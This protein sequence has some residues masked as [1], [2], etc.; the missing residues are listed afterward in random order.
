MLGA[1]GFLGRAVTLRLLRDD[2]QVIAWARSPE[3]ARS[4]LGAEVEIADAGSGRAGLVAALERCDAVINLAGE[5]IAGRWSRA[6]RRRITASR[7]GVTEQLVSAIAA[8][9]RRP[10]VL[11]NASAVGY[12]GDR[13]DQPLDEHSPPGEGFLAETCRRW[14]AA[15][16]AA[17][18]YGLRVVRLRFG[19]VLGLGGGFFARL[20][21]MFARG[22]GARLGGGRQWL[23]FVHLDDAVEVIA[24]ALADDRY[25]GAI[26]V[27][28]PR[29]ATHAQVTA[30][31]GRASG[32]AVRLA[33]PGAAL[34]LVLGEGADIVLASQRLQA[35][36]LA[37]LG[38]DHRFPDIDSALGDLVGRLRAVDIRSLAAG[39]MDQQTDYLRRRRPRYLLRT[40][41]VL[42]APVDQVFRFFSRPENLGILTPAA[43]SF[44][45]RQAPTDIAE[46]GRIDYRIRVAGVPLGWRTTIERWVPGR[47]FVDAQARGP[48]R[49]WWH[50]HHFEPHGDGTRM[51]DRV[52]YA[53]PLG[54][55]G[56]LAQALF[57]AGQLRAVFGYRAQ[58]IAMRFPAAAPAGGSPG[59]GQQSLSWGVPGLVTPRRRAKSR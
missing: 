59:P 5:P 44:R 46:G 54:P 43:M 56:R 51:E 45:I 19:V 20:W 23:P 33:V 29:P 4:S 2:H 42:A 38:F 27:V 26:D 41:V 9:A 50:E 57:V 34:R 47:C 1:T 36:R 52:Y 48:Y 12:Y 58:A 55:L 25:Q 22:L 18:A 15:A 13:G 37:A 21:P 28:A 10:R 30:A 35:R 53:P 31:F 32:R 14:E 3:A 6:R 24:S 16:M 11:I 40:Q 39:A 17:E 7:A 49:S 8:A